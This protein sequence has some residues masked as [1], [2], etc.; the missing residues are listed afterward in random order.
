MFSEVL[1]TPL[2]IF[3]NSIR[4]QINWRFSVYFMESIKNLIGGS[5]KDYFCCHLGSMFRLSSANIY[6]FT[7]TFETLEKD[8]K[9]V[10]T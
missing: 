6:L 3:P 7:V 4:D 8:V 9:Y 1:R 10:Q 2:G 5:R